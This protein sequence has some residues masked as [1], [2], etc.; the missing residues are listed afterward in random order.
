MCIYYII[1]FALD[2]NK[3]EKLK[4]INKIYFQLVYIVLFFWLEIRNLIFFYFF[5]F[6]LTLAFFVML[7][8]NKKIIMIS[9]YK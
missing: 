5:S 6:S 4:D 8:Y 7:N 3:V 2:T 1:F 9:K